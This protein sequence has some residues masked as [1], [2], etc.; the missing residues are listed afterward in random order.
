[1][2][3]QKALPAARR[4]VPLCFLMLL[5]GFAARL[6]W[7]QS[8]AVCGPAP[9][10]KLALDALPEQTPA[11]TDRQYHEQRA[12]DI[13]AL[14]HQYPG[15]VFV[16][17]AY[18][19]SMYGRSDRE[20]VIAEYK[21][22]HEQSPDDAHL[23]YLYGLTL[24]GRQSAEAIKL[25]TGALQKD[26]NFPWP[27][28]ELLTIYSSPA[29]MDKVQGSAHLKAFLDACPTSF[30]GYESLTRID[31]KDFAR[32]YA[33][34]LRTLLASRSDP[35]AVGAYTT[36]WSLEFKVHP[37]S[38]YE[39]LRKQVGQDLERFRQLKLEDKRQWYSALEEGYKLVNDQK[40]SDWAAG[41]GA[42]SFSYALVVAC[43]V[44]V[45]QR[46]PLSGRGCAPGQDTGLLR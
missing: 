35:E 19:D 16:E 39:P 4:V 31:D 40:Q 34:K 32:P 10:V 30:E 11:Q 25:F 41:A 1:M 46:P 17:K 5:M 42:D 37:P 6:G 20:K 22:R 14:L 7:A 36:L 28:L 27:H 2:K 33:A 43:D 29:F 12:A 21:A 24:L 8:G 23:A 9:D 3:T 44:K 45:G 13:Q 18:I 26:P 38:E 15:D